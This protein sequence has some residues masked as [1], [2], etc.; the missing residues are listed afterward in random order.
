[1][2]DISPRFR[3]EVPQFPTGVPQFPTLSAAIPHGLFS[4]PDAI[5]DP[6]NLVPVSRLEVNHRF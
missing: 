6:F 5:G 2:C 4:I 3:Q 1:M